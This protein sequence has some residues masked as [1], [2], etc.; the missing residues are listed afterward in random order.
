MKNMMALKALLKSIESGFDMTD[1]ELV[2]TLKKAAASNTEN[3]P[4]MMLLLMTAERIECLTS[5]YVKVD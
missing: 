1:L 4:L 2:D 5:I 3:L